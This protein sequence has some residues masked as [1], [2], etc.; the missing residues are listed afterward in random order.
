VSKQKQQEETMEAP[1]R[2]KSK[3][4]S[5]KKI[6]KS[7]VR[8]K[9]LIESLRNDYYA[10]REEN[11]RLRSLV[12]ANLSRSAAQDILSQCFDVNAP[13]AKVGNIDDLASKMVGSSVEDD[14]DDDA[15]GF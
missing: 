13:R 3:S 10:L 2:S 14:D 11:D 5:G 15:V 1:R 4:K 9:F 7:G 8:T 6:K 12:E